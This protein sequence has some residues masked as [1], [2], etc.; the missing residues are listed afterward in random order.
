MH[1]SHVLPSSV[2][3]RATAPSFAQRLVLPVLQRMKHGC[4]TL[5]LP[6]GSQQ[7]LGARDAAVQAEMTIH[8]DAFFQ[9][10]LR[11][12]D[13]GF[14]EAYVDGNWDTPS[15]ERVIAWAIANIDHSPGMSGSRAKAMALN[16]LRSLNRIQHL[17]RP[18]TK[19]TAQQNIAEHYDLGN[20]FY[21]LW[22]DE[23]LTYSSGI[24]TSPH[25]TLPDAQ[26]AKYEALCQKVKLC[27]QDEVL[28]IGT[29]WGGF[30]CYAA[31]RYGCRVTT[32]TISEKQF[33]YAT[34]RVA[35]AGLSDRIT[36]LMQDYRDLSGQY[37][38][39]ISIEMMEALGD[40]YLRPYCAQLHRLL[41]P[42]GLVGL[43]YITV[44]DSRHAELRRGVDWIQKHIF[45]GSL[46]LSI[47]RVSQTMA[48]TGDLFLHNL[49]DIGL[50]YARTL[51]LWWE[52]FNQ[53]LPEVR[54]Q[55]FDETFI[56]KW[57]YYLQYCEA[58]FATR[59][60]SVVQAIY[61]RPNNPLLC[62]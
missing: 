49:Q 61:T 53:K 4:L 23:T 27:A 62:S 54:A 50:S 41:K 34:E 5:T 31:E 39:I 57:N 19:T 51:H 12:G 11:Y 14:G 58:A 1:K 13:I 60:I 48:R 38:K 46:L 16:F 43:Q 36:V 7:L 30:A 9:K 2:A 29:G 45:P 33:T 32:V 22:L 37:D 17:L 56:R 10:V 28:E 20:D 21:K 8:H 40:K 44:P 26:L 3:Q 35:R 25:T 55:G 59:N 24:F 15:I 52:T 47:G 6:D 18:N 42:A